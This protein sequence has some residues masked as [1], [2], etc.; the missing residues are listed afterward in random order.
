M[1]VFAQEMHEAYVANDVILQLMHRSQDKIDAQFT[2][3][4]WLLESS[5]KRMIYNHLYGDLLNER[6]ERRVVLDIGGGYASLTKLLVERQDYML[7]DIMAHD[8]PEALRRIEESL[9]AFWCGQDWYEFEPDRRY[10]VVIANDLFPNV[11]QRLELFVQRFLPVCNEM[12]FSLTY[13]NTPRFYNVKRVD[14]DEALCLLAWDGAQVRHVLEA[15][16]GSIREPDF[17]ILDSNPPS[18]FANGRRV[19]PGP[20]AGRPDN[21]HVLPPPLRAPQCNLQMAILSYR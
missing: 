14:A 5:V 12:R 11:D 8:P 20:E 2:S 19:S 3:H 4:R 18:L 16:V 21:R 1:T 15:H 7:V 13:Y 9:G 17:A 10:D 6:S